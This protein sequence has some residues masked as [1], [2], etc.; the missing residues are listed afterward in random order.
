MEINMLNICV[1]GASYQWI[2]T[3]MP[4]IYDVFK[5]PFE[6]RFLEIDLKAAEDCKSWSETASKALGRKDKYI[7][8]LDRETAL[9]DADAVIITI[10][11]GSL[12]A[13]EH[14][15]VIP[16]KYGIYGVVGDTSGPG[17]WSRSIRNIPVFMDFAADFNKYCPNAFIANYTNPMSSLTATL[18]LQSYNPTVGLCHAYFGTKDFIQAIFDLPNWDKMSLSIAGMN[19]FTFVIDFNIGNQKGY[20][21]LEKTLNGKSLKEHVLQSKLASDEFKR[22]SLVYELFDTYGYIPYPA[23][24]H[25]SEFVPYAISNYPIVTDGFDSE[26]DENTQHLSPYNTP[27][28]LIENRR[29][30]FVK[31]IDDMY[32]SSKEIESGNM[33]KIKRSKETGAEM[34]NAYIN[35]K[36]FV[37]AVNMI[38]TG[39][40]SGLPLG[41]CVETLGAIDGLGVHPLMV[42]EISEPLLELMR[43]QA[44]SQKWITEGCIEGNK[45][46]VLNALYI[47][48]QCKHLKP[49]Q[50][51]EMAEELIIANSKYIKLTI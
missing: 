20:P 15:I 48:P 6:L 16:E 12:D 33:K 21:L 28:K 44:N 2:P 7:A 51:N 9:K 47:D 8:T 45:K 23:D 31:R 10:S 42:G 34:I 26:K 19:H 25:I 46:K 3:L 41:A 17:G 24:Q 39:Q 5:E 43:P 14:D 29:K 18:Q 30:Y 11:T 38:N 1:I 35:N 36:P 13:M 50:I 22:D 27:R 49:K 37:D 40:I 4:D 32:N